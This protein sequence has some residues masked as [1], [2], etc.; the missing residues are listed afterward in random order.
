MKSSAGQQP[1]FTLLG[2]ERLHTS[3]V[4]RHQLNGGIEDAAVEGGEI[5]LLNKQGADFLQSQR[6]VSSWA[7]VRRA[8]PVRY[9]C[10]LSKT[11][12][13]FIV[14]GEHQPMFLRVQEVSFRGRVPSYFRPLPGSSGTLVALPNQLAQPLK[15]PAMTSVDPT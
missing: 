11:F 13:G 6:L 14:A 8:P 12:D 3:H 9:C 5:A 4:S 1:K 10:E 2:M 15:H 7:F